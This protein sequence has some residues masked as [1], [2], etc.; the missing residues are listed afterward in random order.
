MSSGID[1]ISPS[2]LYSRVC[3][4]QHESNATWQ[5]SFS[6]GSALTVLATLRDLVETGDIVHKIQESTFNEESSFSEAL[7]QAVAKE[8][9]ESDIREGLSGFDMTRKV[10]I[11]ARQ[12]GIDVE[13]EDVEVESSFLTGDMAANENMK[14]EDLQ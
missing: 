9:T 2:R 8:F 7:A 11:L 13:L 3:E 4:A 1:I 12:L 6:V 10:V 5:Y 14:A